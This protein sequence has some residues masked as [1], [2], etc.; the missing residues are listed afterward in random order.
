VSDSTHF[1][2]PSLSLDLTSFERPKEV[3]KKGR[4][5]SKLSSLRD[6]TK[7]DLVLSLSNKVGGPHFGTAE[8][9]K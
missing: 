5:A 9:E 4:S 7:I 8:E 6:L 3:S 2:A 1:R